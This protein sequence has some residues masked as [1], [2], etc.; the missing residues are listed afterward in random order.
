MTMAEEY[1]TPEQLE[2]LAERREALGDDAIRRAEAD[3][4][5]LIAGGER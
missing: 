2:Q 1:D 4:A 5:S 3:W